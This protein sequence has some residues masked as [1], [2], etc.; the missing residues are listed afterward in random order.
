MIDASISATNIYGLWDWFKMIWIHATGQSAKMVY[1]QTFC[2]WT[3][4]G[5][6]AVPV[7][8]QGRH[9]EAR[10]EASIAGWHYISSPEPAPAIGFWQNVAFKVLVILKHLDRVRRD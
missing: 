5:F 3:L 1:D 7:S 4:M 9:P 8:V 10:A 6:V 2:Y